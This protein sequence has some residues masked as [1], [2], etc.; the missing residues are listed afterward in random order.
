MKR[1]NPHTANTG[2][3][4]RNSMQTAYNTSRAL[5]LNN[6]SSV[7]IGLEND[8]EREQCVEAMEGCPVE[9]IGDD[10]AK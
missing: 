1:R 2:S 3:K 7:S 9:A 4:T 10:G 8:D 6:P 5:N